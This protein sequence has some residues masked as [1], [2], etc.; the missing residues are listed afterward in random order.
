V[1]GIVSDT[2]SVAII[3]IGGRTYIV[4]PG[5]VVLDKI[6]VAAVDVIKNLVVLEE[7]GERFELKMGGV[8]G[9]HVAAPAPTN[10]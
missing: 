5:D 4:S 6:R 2:V 10:N 8:S 1:V 3:R 9:A 7:D